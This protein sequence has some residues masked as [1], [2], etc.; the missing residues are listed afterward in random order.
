MLSYI[1]YRKEL[2]ENKIDCVEYTK[3]ALQ[4]IKD[5][6]KLNAFLTIAE[7]SALEQA[8]QSAKMF[9]LGTPRKLEGMLIAV[10]DNI[11]T[12]DIR[13]TCGSKMLENFNPL[14]DATVVQRI[15]EEGGIIVG[16]TNMDEFAMGSSNETSFFGPVEH[17][18]DPERI[19]G[20]SS[21]G[22]AVAVAANLV[23]TSL[24]SDTGGSIRQP[25]ALVGVFGTKPT[26]GRVS[27]YGLVAFASSLDQIGVFS[28]TAEDNALLLDV[29]SGKDEMDSTIAPYEPCKSF[30][31]LSETI[32]AKFICGVMDEEVI[33]NC[34]DEVLEAYRKSLEIIKSMGGELRTVKFDYPE[35]WLPTY[36][37]LATAEASANLSR[38]DGVKYG[39]RADFDENDDMVAKT[40]TEGFGEEVKRRIMLGTY[41]L[42]SGYY[43][44]YYKKAQQ[45]RRLIFNNYKEIFSQ[46]DILFIPTTP[47]PAFK[48]NE[49]IDDPVA[50]YLSDF[51]TT[52]ANLAGNPGISVPAG[53]TKSGLPIGMQF[54]ANHFEEAKLMQF[55]KAFAEKM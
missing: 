32:P 9:E 41:V 36:Y 37:I 53:V 29:I 14:F 38:F 51:F 48:R 54:Q 49:K 20:G 50:M 13:T 43:D 22:S 47:T 24:G 10:K 6:S 3:L 33:K 39:F 34:D 16:K 18:L 26:Y 12:K 25:A 40:R 31:A 5:N 4:K 11:S 46:V 19:P 15:K 45:V 55:A 52:S 17:P 21:G 8:A 42:S 27:R 28:R 44:A 30:E 35:A 23:H 1:E 7:D 2:L